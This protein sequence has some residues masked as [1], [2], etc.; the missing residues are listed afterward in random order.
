MLRKFCVIFFI[1][2][3]L[4]PAYSCSELIVE[5]EIDIT[6]FVVE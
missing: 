2:L 3:F 6:E 1:C 5:D 4:L